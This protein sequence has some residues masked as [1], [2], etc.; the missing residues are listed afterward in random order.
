MI[1]LQNESSQSHQIDL[2]LLVLA[3]QTTLDKFQKSDVD[4]TLRL[5]DDHEMQALNHRFRGIN[6]T[7]DVLSFNQDFIDPDTGIYYLGDLIIS[8]DRASQQASENQHTLTEEC[9]F[10]AIHGTL[11][12]LGYNHE[13]PEQ[14]AIMWRLQDQ[15][16]ECIFKNYE[17]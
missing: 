16:F 10:L 7:T 1:H 4:L 2:D 15:I 13:E 11:H 5:T 8:V 9:V 6:A 14:K 12:L 3:I 17:E